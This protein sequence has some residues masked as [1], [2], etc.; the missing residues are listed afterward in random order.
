MVK[1][2][3]VTRVYMC[4]WIYFICGFGGRCEF[5][6]IFQNFTLNCR[7]FGMVTW[8]Q[9]NKHNSFNAWEVAVKDLRLL[10]VTRIWSQSKFYE[11]NCSKRRNR[12][13]AMMVINMTNEFENWFLFFI[14]SVLCLSISASSSSLRSVRSVCFV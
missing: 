4:V 5:M 2:F 11:C 10:N 13:R 7:I 12:W 3:S 1:R 6:N 9:S 14:S 8:K